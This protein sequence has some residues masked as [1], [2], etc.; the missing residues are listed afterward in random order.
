MIVLLSSTPYFGNKIYTILRKFR[1]YPPSVLRN[2]REV[3]VS[4][5]A[6]VFGKFSSFLFL[7]AALR[8]PGVFSAGKK[9][10]YQGVSLG[11]TFRHRASSV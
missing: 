9:S 1:K 4:I 6:I 10:E 8:S 11:L 5:P 3:P 2:N 7:L